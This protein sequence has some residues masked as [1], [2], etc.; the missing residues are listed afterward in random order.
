[1]NLSE[2]QLPIRK[3]ALL[4]S[5]TMGSQIA[6]HCVNAALPTILYGLSSDPVDP[7]SAAYA[8]NHLRQMKPP[9]L[10]DAD[11]THS[12]I[13][14][15]YQQLDLLK[16]CDL[17]IE[18]VSEDLTVKQGLYEK[19]APY[20][21]ED[22]I[23]VSNTSSI[24]IEKLASN[25][26]ADLQSRFCGMHF[27]NPPRYM[28]LVELIPS[29]H[30][31]SS[32]LF[33]LEGF[34]TS[35]LGKHIIVAKDTAG[36]VANRFGLF[37]LMSTLH[38][39]ERI[40]L[41]LDLVDELTGQL[42]GRPKSATFRTIDLVGIDILKNVCTYLYDELIDDPWR[43]V[44]R[45]PKWLEDLADQG[46]LGQKT[47][48]GI[49]HKQEDGTIHVLDRQ[50]GGYVPR[51]KSL[52]DE[53][54]QLVDHHHTLDFEAAVVS[55]HPQAQFLYAIHRDFFHYVAHHALATVH[56]LGDIDLAL[57]WGFGWQQGVFE[58]WQKIGWQI[59]CQRLQQ[60]I[61]SG[62]AL[63]TTPLANWALN[64]NCHQIY[65]D[66]K[67]W[68]PE[69]QEHIATTK[70]PVYQKQL[71]AL[72]FCNQSIA[73]KTIFE[74]E[75][76]RL[77]H[78]DDEIAIASL[79]TKMHALNYQAITSLAEAI[80][81]AEERYHGLLIWQQQP[82]FCVGANL[83]EV[84]LA[85]KAGKL[86]S[87]SLISQAKSMLLHI[88]KPDLPSID[89]LP[90]IDEVVEAL[91][92]T[93]MRLRNSH[94]PTVAVVQGLALGGGCELLLHCDRVV[95]AMESYIG[96]VEAGVG[97]LPA[98]GGC[99]EMACRAYLESEPSETFPRL[100]RYYQ[101]IAT[102]QVS[103]S[104]LE[105]QR[106]GYLRSGDTIV[107]NSYELL[108]AAKQQVRALCAGGYHPPQ[109]EQYFTV[110]GSTAAANLKAYVVNLHQGNYISDYDLHLA[111]VI[112][113]L[114]CGA[115][116][117]AGQ[118]VTASWFLKNEKCAFLGL[119]KQQKTQ[120]RIEYMLK[121]NKPLRN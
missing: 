114:F 54:K 113:E 13:A 8:I 109:L 84:L 52:A 119:L 15:D 45:L 59:V 103:G 75:S 3:V 98:G 101:Q 11:L 88:A 62:R 73:G 78:D 69:H 85:A 100:Q 34:A 24:S 36:F 56:S 21:R 90:P 111:N 99:K 80:T 89:D 68:S 82:P 39:A 48:Q 49:Y 27:F 70:H 94:I 87:N 17:V 4:G 46:H 105:A 66:E 107:M 117:S 6:A 93:F 74:N 91:Q 86:T 67:V 31:A 35:Q 26:P 53:A 58:H 83:L 64:P 1:M 55:N 76:L 96:L 44:F 102:A 65:C 110:A 118:R 51:Q 18:A 106:M 33:T 7:N 37:A 120:D 50:T 116:L 5:G 19:I 92:D 72:S 71:F 29:S 20:L 104:A 2:R 115:A 16:T 60:D 22:C 23:L 121:H 42:I 25:L 41:N 79:K 12:L 77:W 14:A 47:G 43:S 57:R 28:G 38:H 30:T 95:A 81:I 108:Y 32:I 112:A 63:S 61:S 9:P 40:S 10:V 97:L